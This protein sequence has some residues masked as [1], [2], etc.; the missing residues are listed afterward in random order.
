LA[1]Q[2]SIKAYIDT[3]VAATNELVEDTTPQLGGDLDL[4]S[5]NITGTGNIDVTGTVTADG[6]TVD[7]TV[8]GT[9]VALL[10]ADNNSVTKKNT[11][12]FED[13]DTT[14]Q[15]DQQIGRIEFYS[16]DTD[17]TGVDAVIEAVSATNGLKELRFLTSDTANTPLS[18]L[19][20]DKSGNISFYDTDGTTSSFV[21]D[22]SAGLTI[23]EAAADRD[24]RVESVN[25]QY[26]LF[27][28][29]GNDRVGINENA[30]T[31]ALH[32]NSGANGNIIQA[33]GSA[34]AWD[35]ILK[36][37]NDGAA[38]SILYEMGMYRDD[39][40]TNPNTV[41][42]FGRGGGVQNGFFVIDQNGTEALRLSNN[43]FE[44]NDDSNNLDFRVESDSN[45]HALF[46]DAGNNSVNIAG[47]SDPSA[48][49]LIVT[50]SANA[51]SASHRPAILGRGSYGGGIASLDTLESGW[52]QIT[53][54]TIWNFYHGRDTSSDTPDSKI[55]QTFNSGETVFNES[56]R[57]LDFRVESDNNSHML[58]V[59]AENDFVG[60]NKSE[61]EVEL[62]VRSTAAGAMTT[63]ESS[64]ANSSGGPNIRLWRNSSSPAD[65]DG[66]SRL[67]FQGM[68]SADERIDYV[69]LQT[70][71]ENVTDGA[72]DG[73]FQLETLVAGTSRTRLLINGSE[74]AFNDGG[75]NLDFR[76]E[77]DSNA[78]GFFL[79]A[80]KK[81][82]GVNF[83]SNPGAYAQFGVRFSGSDSDV[84]STGLAVQDT[85]DSSNVSFCTFFNGLGS[86]IGS[87]T[88]VGTTNAVNY[89]TTS[90]RRAKQNIADADDAGAVIDA[91][92]VRKFDWIEGNQHQPYGMIAQELVE[93]A[94]EVVHQPANEEDMMG[95]DY[96]K[97][98]PML[99][100]EIQSLRARV[101][102]L[103][104]N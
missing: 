38:D 7:G 36:G 24:F 6:L 37:T 42:K 40:S 47:A 26:M 3:T 48:G 54:G 45:T 85:A 97:L 31:A 69:E 76:V 58:F 41:L 75:R 10:R 16:N 15:N 52:Y 88:R 28:D 68:N 27:V 1:T 21:Y 71:I 13:T 73:L 12:R 72:E 44:F 9:A 70:E 34:T 83:D 100:K 89:N 98:V 104:S 90:D 87:I 101:A 30:P 86:G 17:H 55:V 59:D 81:A 14:T 94:P 49:N 63:F 103:E 46:V 11:L 62:H 96:S 91:I 29:A 67:I 20:I 39:G 65:G 51:A 23:N 95:V 57:D 19:A 92:Q 35:F 102:Q 84:N 82:V 32:V 77:S 64:S 74:S 22:A 60:I 18:R 66:L 2:Q 25:K 5:N 93:H 79:D 61:P 50:G 33:N 78:Y 80:S 8:D 56:S 53:S 43:G 99:V 4:N